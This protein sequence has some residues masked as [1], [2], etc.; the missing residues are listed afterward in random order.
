MGTL[1]INT[2]SGD[3]TLG[4]TNVSFELQYHE[5][6]CNKDHY[7]GPV[8]WESIIRLLKGTAAVM[9]R[10]LGPTISIDH[11]VQ[12]L[13][14]IFD[15]VA[16]FSVLMQNFYKVTQGNEKI[17]SFAMVEGDPKSN[18]ASVPQKNDRPGDT[19]SPQGLPLPWG[20]QTHL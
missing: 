7:P 14:V 20:L 16:S 15:M 18:P 6:Q 2:F 13:L 19:T 9:A 4:N 10:Y 12:K 8:F 5:V 3:A 17:P 1:R 11:I